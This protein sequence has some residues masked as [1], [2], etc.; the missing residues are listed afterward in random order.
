MFEFRFYDVYVHVCIICLYIYVCVCV[1]EIQLNVWLI[2]ITI[3]DGYQ[4]QCEK[5][6]DSKQSIFNI[7]H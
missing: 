7:W 3:L 4:K 5:H 6:D 2:F 1:Y